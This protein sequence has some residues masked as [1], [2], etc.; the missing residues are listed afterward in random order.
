[1]NA[2]DS[3]KLARRFIGL[4]LEKRQLFL[5]ALQK[6]GVDFSRFPIPAGVEAQD[7]QALSYAQ[8]RMWFLWQLDPTSGAY[9]LPGAVRLKVALNLRAMEQAFASLVAR[10]ETLR[11]VFQRQADERLVQ[12]AVEPSLAIEHLDISA[13]EPTAREQAVN[14]AA[15]RQSLLPFDLEHGPL[16]RVQLLKLDAQEH[17]LLLTLHHI[18]SD[19]W[20]MNV[21]I[22]EFIR[23]YDAHERNDTPQ[24]PPLPIQ[25]SDYALWQ[26][27]WLEA[28]EQARQLDYWQARLG[29]E[30]P[31]LELPTDR[32]RPAMPSYQG[33][34]HTFAI[35]PALAVQLRNCAQKHN[36]TLFMLLLGAFNVLLHRYTG[37][38]DLRIGVPIANRN[39]SEVEGLIGFFVNTQVLRTELTGQTRVAELLHAIKEHA[40]GAQDHQELPFE[41]LVEALKVERSLSHTPLFQVMYNHQP[42]VADIASVRTASGLELALVEWQGRTTQFDLTLDTYEKSGTLHAALTYANDLFDAP[43]IA[44]MARHWIRLLQAMVADGEQRIG[45]LPM[46]A[47]DEQH[48]LVQAWNQ[49]AAPYPTERAMHHLIEDQVQRTPDAPALVFGTTTLT[50]AQ[51]DAH[52]NQLAHA[53]RE[54]GVGPDVLVGIC[55]ERSL[56]MVVGLLAILKAGGAYVP[57]D[58]E[59]PEQRLEH[60]FED[61][62]IKVLLTQTALQDVIPEHSVPVLLLD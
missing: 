50:Y 23:F 51:L 8:Q 59:Y 55:V 40:L 60:M 34:R 57:L 52:A 37:Q 29:D 13:L 38:V 4:P 19:G 44:R 1:M 48:L 14:Q 30:H 5:Q 36:V 22:D 31:V 45:E 54:Q 32:P 28:G 12:V 24:L 33:T 56:H 20:S 27:C 3:L 10:H 53:L 58:P 21:L 61:A 46:L 17:V 42:V 25:Y 26:R 11:T 6:E 43:S 7:R 16:L 47:A 41:R 15:T 9:N 18:V 39:R 49:T 2:E 62:D 35:D